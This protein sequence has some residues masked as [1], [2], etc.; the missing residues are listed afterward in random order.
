MRFTR[1]RFSEIISD[2]IEKE[3]RWIKYYF[4]KNC[5][6]KIQITTK[7]CQIKKAFRKMNLQNAFYLRIQFIYLPTKPYSNRK[8]RPKASINIITG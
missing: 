3:R 6:R 7:L 5:L 8:I 1:P 2:L 4:K